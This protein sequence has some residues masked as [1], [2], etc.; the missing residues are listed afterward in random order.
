[1]ARQKKAT[2][3]ADGLH[4]VRLTFDGGARV[5]RV[6]D[7]ELLDYQRQGVIFEGDSPEEDDA[8][9]DDETDDEREELIP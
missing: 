1:M 5:H 7:A 8:P 9:V 3:S 4:D 2:A 6:G